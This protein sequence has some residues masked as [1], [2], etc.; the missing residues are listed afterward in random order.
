[1]P[2]YRVTIKETTTMSYRPVV[3]EA[4]DAEA[5]QEE[6]E[7]WRVQGWAGNPLFDSVDEVEIT[8]TEVSDDTPLSEQG[9]EQ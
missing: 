8:T 4:E 5:A 6:A 2:K 3:I 9:L 1:M 7:E